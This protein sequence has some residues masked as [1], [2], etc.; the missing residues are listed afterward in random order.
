MQLLE[1]TAPDS[2]VSWGFFNGIFERKEYMEAY[3]AEEAAREML[4]RDLK[5]KE[6]FEARLKS[7]PAFAASPGQRLYF[8]ASRHPSHDERLN[9][10]PIYRT[11]TVMK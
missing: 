5:L 4:A 9:L 3:V 6:E 2:F 11:S 10:Y 7:D 8:F 1:P